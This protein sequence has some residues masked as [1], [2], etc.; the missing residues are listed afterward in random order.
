MIK[1]R[2]KETYNMAELKTKWGF[3]HF[4]S[5]DYSEVSD[6]EFEK[7]ILAEEKLQRK[8]DELWDLYLRLYPDQEY[9]SLNIYLDKEWIH[10][11]NAYW[12]KDKKF[13]IRYSFNR[14]DD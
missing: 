3:N 10:V 13:P 6:E 8:I 9:D 14:K 1:L 12:G 5:T 7:I 2:K 11:H 4:A